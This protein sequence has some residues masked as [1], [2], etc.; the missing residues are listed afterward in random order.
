MVLI[1]TSRVYIPNKPVI[2]IDDHKT[3][4]NIATLPLA[5]YLAASQSDASSWSDQ[6]YIDRGRD[7][8]MTFF[9]QED[10]SWFQGYIMVNGWSVRINEIDM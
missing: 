4:R 2:R 10:G 9:L 3:G 6:E 5:Y 7:W 1:S 8:V